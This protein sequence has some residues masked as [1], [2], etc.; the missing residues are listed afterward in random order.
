[1]ERP[2]LATGG[3][4]MKKYVKPQ[5]YAAESK[6]HRYAGTF[7]VLVP[8]PDRVKPHRIAQ[9]FASLQA[10][11]GWIHSDEGKDAIAEVFEAHKP[12]KAAKR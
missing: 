7:E 1:M 8:L 9:Q 11:E 2:R 3:L 10:A 5:A 12:A 6:D 4:P